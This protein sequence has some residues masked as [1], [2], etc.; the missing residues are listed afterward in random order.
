MSY[1]S[2]VLD[3]PGKAQTVTVYVKLRDMTL[4]IR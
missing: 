4:C 1:P 2:L 3:N